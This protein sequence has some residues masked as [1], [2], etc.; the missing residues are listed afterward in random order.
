MKIYLMLMT[1][2]MMP[3]RIKFFIALFVL[4]AFACG[5]KTQPNNNNVETRLDTA[6]KPEKPVDGEVTT[7]SFP[8]SPNSTITKKFGE[9]EN[10]L[11]CQITSVCLGDSAVIDTLQKTD[12]ETIL[13][14]N[15]NYKH[16][17]WLKV[18]GDSVSYTFTKKSAFEVEGRD[19][20]VLVNPRLEKN[21]N[22]PRAVNIY[23][24]LSPPNATKPK[25]CWFIASID[26]GYEFMGFVEE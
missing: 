5:Q 14:K 25:Q 13:A 6:V 8:C 4:M 24:T 3:M 18:K 17:L 15:S 2:Y 16:E 7:I 12:A 21:E 26:G 9:G 19:N 22:S 20:M 1:K 11:L 23:F 10:W